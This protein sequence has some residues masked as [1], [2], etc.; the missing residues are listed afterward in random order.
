[1]E[2]LQ[3]AREIGMMAIKTLVTLNSGAIV[4]LLTFVSNAGSQSAFT[5]N[6]QSIKVAFFLFLFGIVSTG[7]LIALAYGVALT[8]NP[9]TGTANVKVIPVSWESP[10][11]FFLAFLSLTGFAVGV[12]ILALN[13]TA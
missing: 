12:L 11:Y 9:H 3:N 10:C 5:F 4:V 6:L 13:V 2:A 7:L 1:M 8:S